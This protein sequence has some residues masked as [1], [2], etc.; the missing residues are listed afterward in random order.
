MIVG[1]DDI[2]KDHVVIIFRLS[3]VLKCRM[4]D[5]LERY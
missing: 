4:E 5:L 3:V 2:N 1:K